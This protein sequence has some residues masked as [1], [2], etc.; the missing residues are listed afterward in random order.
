VAEA[1]FGR[2][3]YG[4]ANVGNL[5]RA[6][7]EGEARGL[8]ETAWACGIR[9]FDTAPHYGLGLSERRLGAFLAT[10]PRDEYTVSTKVGRLLRPD[11]EG[12]GR[13]DL[14]HDFAVPADMR[15]VWDFSE[16]GIRRSLSESLERLGLD[17]VD[18][19]YLHDPEEHDLDAA[20]ATGVPALVALRE[21]GLVS[22]VGVGSKST[23]ALLAGVRTGGLDLL[24]V[25]GR[26]TLVEQPALD[27]VVPE[28][29][30]R[31]VGVVNAAVFNS[32]LLASNTPSPE[33]RYEYRRVPDDVL[34]RAR[35]IAAV[36][37]ELGVELP[38]AAL[39]YTL[40]EPVVRTVVVGGATPEQIR[41]NADRMSAVVPEELWQRLSAEG[42]VR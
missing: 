4:A 30:A 13:L 28:C 18:I 34:A 20:L 24:M 14:D 11:P 33:A 15:R 39:Q 3:S 17:A 26:F 6:L 12:A 1:R 8:L 10:K 19:L 41:Q 38:T 23:A 27:E 31:N 36:C 5:Y 40:R 16:A 21:E 29:R 22:A 25:A 9:Y 2:L 42:L 7:D 37:A 35:A 32:G